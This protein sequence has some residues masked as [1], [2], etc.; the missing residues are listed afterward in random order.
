M[1]IRRK[2]DDP[3]GKP[4]PKIKEPKKRK[5]RPDHHDDDSSVDSHG[6]IR[7]LIEYDAE[8]SDNL[9][10]RESLATPVSKKQP[11]PAKSSGRPPKRQAAL[12]AEKKIER[13][14]ASEEK[15]R[16]ERRKNQE[17]ED[18]KEDTTT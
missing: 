6:N 4:S 13:K 16:K 1:P 15:K 2:N 9:S 12:A 3:K 7:D 10:Y 11:T 8:D 14:L 18:K 5:G 17:E